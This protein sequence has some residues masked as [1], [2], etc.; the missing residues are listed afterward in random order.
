MATS[1]EISPG[2]ATDPV[3]EE[4]LRRFAVGAAMAFLIL[5]P[6]YA[7]LWIFAGD[8]AMGSLLLAST[9][10][11]ILVRSALKNGARPQRLSGIFAG[12][13]LLLITCGTWRTGGIGSLHTVWFLVLPLLGTYLFGPRGCL[14]LSV[15]S[16]LALAGL[17]TWQE[18]VGAH[19]LQVSDAWLPV[20]NIAALCGFALS[21]T[22]LTA[23]WRTTAEFERDLREQSE[24]GFA[25]AVQ[26]M[27]DAV[28]V[29]DADGKV[30][31]G[32][33]AA[34]SLLNLL[35][36][37]VDGAQAWL[38]AS[39][40]LPIPNGLREGDSLELRHPIDGRHFDMSNCKWAGRYVLTLHD[41]SHRVALEEQLRRV[42]EEAHLASRAKSEFL[43]NMSHEIRTPMNGILGMAEIAMQDTAD[44]SMTD[45][46]RT[47]RRCGNSMLSLLNDI[48]DLSRIEAGHM[49]LD[50]IEFN[51]RQILD[52]VHE[53]LGGTATLAGLQ[54]RCTID[55]EVPAG[56]L[57]DHHRL[58]Q[59]LINLAGNALKFTEIGE[60]HVD[61]ALA[62]RTEDEARL[63]FTVTD[64]GMIDATR[65]PA[66]GWR[67][68][69][70]SSDAWADGLMC[71]ARS[72]EGRPSA[73]S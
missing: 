7:M 61:L 20:L 18:L 66:S 26:N 36:D 72:V 27:S 49:E 10:P 59:V 47:I 69:R 48:L 64:T 68:R 63:R 50:H 40:G 43:A 30:E 4:A 9:L 16:T 29:L 51:P 1:S 33:R 52:E 60:V 37:G 58:R 44:E 57:G 24:R 32:N 53:T 8:I 41:V 65:A 19:T 46:L 35:P 55:S 2:A 34:T 25:R 22:L 67:S 23:H 73:L 11:A 31:F 3:T 70:N 21:T 5:A 42:G 13:V 45:K 39:A 56:L 54:M 62:S 17:W 15:L 28:L 38:E 12:V 71:K 6:L 14:A